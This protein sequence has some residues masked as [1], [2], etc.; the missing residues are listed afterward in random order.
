MIASTSES[1]EQSRSD[2]LSTLLP[3]AA[4]VRHWWET[5]VTYQIYVRSF[6]DSNGDGIGDIAG[7]ASRI[8]YLDSLGV[9]AIWLTPCYPSP[10][11]DHGYD[12]A[13][14]CDIE[15]DYGTLNDFDSLITT[16]KT[17]DIR[18][19]MDIVPNHCS[20]EHAWFQLAL[21]AEPGSEPRD[22][23]YFRD[24][25]GEGGNEPP[26]NW[27][28]LFGGPAWHRTT[29]ADGTPGQWY[30]HMF[31]P[32]QPDLNWG[33]EPVAAAFDNTLRFWFDRGVEGFRVDAVLVVG[34]EPLENNTPEFPP[35]APPT[36]VFPYQLRF[37]GPVHSLMERW[38]AL[39]DEYQ[40]AHPGRDLVFVSEAY[41]SIEELATYVGPTRFHTSFEFD[42]LLT[43]WEVDR[44]RTYIADAIDGLGSRH[45]PMTWT[46]NNHDTQRS[47]T[48][49]GHIDAHLPSS[50]TGNNLLHSKA[51]VD[52]ELGARRARALIVMTAGLPGSLYLY[53]GEELGLPEVLDL[54]EWALQDPIW[55]RTNHAERGRDGCRMPFPWTTDPASNF[56]FSETQPGTHPAPAWLPLPV[57]WGTYAASAQ[58]HDPTSFLSLHRSI[59]AARAS[60][61][62]D[63]SPSNF[64]WVPSD[65]SILAYRNASMT[66]VANIGQTSIDL[67]PLI[68]SGRIVLASRYG[69]DDRILEPA[70]AVWIV[71]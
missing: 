69:Q 52:S 62:N 20:I 56:G 54:P 9:D 29:A 47:V 46:L 41:A 49:H 31:A 40:R 43:N 6:A 53:Y 22:W 32:E 51:L 42:L 10:Q 39:A 5:A 14:Y 61:N 66:V 33:H 67:A 36:D 34:K 59:L 4:N 16:T 27:R 8:P 37:G 26:N 24:G 57:D 18:V 64:S 70:D 17:H 65:R 30:L 15:P 19:L 11:A 7:I 55:V 45:L 71:G 23:F 48:R 1:S 50:F 12:V 25:R 21:A 28:S 38:R 35:D 68:G 63:P 3:D 60:Y 44:M 58:L 13:D 2:G